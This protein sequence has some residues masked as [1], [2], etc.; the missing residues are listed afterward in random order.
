MVRR[1]R[2]CNHKVKGWGKPKTSR[3]KL[4]IKKAMAEDPES[5]EYVWDRRLELLIVEAVEVHDGR[6]VRI[7]YPVARLFANGEKRMIG[8]TKL[9]LKK[10]LHAALAQCTEQHGGCWRME[11]TRAK[12]QK[13]LSKA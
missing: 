8:W 5:F 4:R 9:K 3:E 2:H 11:I 7:H 13:T 1:Y 10:S 12:V 6:R